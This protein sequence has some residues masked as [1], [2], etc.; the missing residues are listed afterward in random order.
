MQVKRLLEMLQQDDC[1]DSVD[2]DCS[3]PVS[4]DDAADLPA[5]PPCAANEPPPSPF[6]PWTMLNV[7]DVSGEEPMLLSFASHQTP[8]KS[9][10]AADRDDDNVMTSSGRCRTFKQPDVQVRLTS[11]QQSAATERVSDP[12]ADTVSVVSPTECHQRP[13]LYGRI[14]SS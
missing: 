14:A 8:P 9:S 10:F 12:S 6:Q 7:D 11:P 1:E 4:E 2:C 3:L 5:D 13:S